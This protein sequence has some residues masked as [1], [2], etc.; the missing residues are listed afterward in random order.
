M[1]PPLA[2][3]SFEA[4]H[5]YTGI[6]KQ[7]PMRQEYLSHL[8][9]EIARARDAVREAHCRGESGWA[10]V[11]LFTD[12]MDHLLEGLYSE[13]LEQGPPVCLVALGGYGRSELCPHSD[14]DIMFLYRAEMYAGQLNEQDLEGKRGTA[15]LILAKHRNGPTGTITLAFNK[16]CT[17]FDSYTAREGTP[18]AF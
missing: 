2:N 11:G 1:E 4:T 3:P 16:E 17:R 9:D 18:D 14:I 15:E 6:M 5:L 10:V 8:K 13:F 7:G 12:A